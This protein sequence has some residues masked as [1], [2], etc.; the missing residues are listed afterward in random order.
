MANLYTAS[1]QER[2]GY[3]GDKWGLKL[4]DAIA[5]DIVLGAQPLPEDNRAKFNVLIYEDADE[6]STIT[7]LKK[8]TD[9]NLED[10]QN[11]ILMFQTRAIHHVDYIDDVEF[12]KAFEESSPNPQVGDSYYYK[13]DKKGN[14]F[15]AIVKVD[16]SKV[17]T[18]EWSEE[19]ER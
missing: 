14:Y 13:K 15:F 19:L 12:T 5:Q 10:I 17:Y 9:E 7:G 1:S 3:H 16:E 2:V 4:P 11:E 6:F 8:I 18:F